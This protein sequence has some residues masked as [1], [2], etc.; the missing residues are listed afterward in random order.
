[1]GAECD[2]FFSTRLFSMQNCTI[3]TNEIINKENDLCDLSGSQE[4]R[5]K[6]ITVRFHSIS[7]SGTV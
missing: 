3:C 7:E 4:K 6:I 2:C 1:M 5:T